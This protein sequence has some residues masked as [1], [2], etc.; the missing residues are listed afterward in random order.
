MPASNWRQAVRQ[1]FKNGHLAAHLGALLDGSWTAR[2][3]CS[4]PQ[5]LAG[6]A[7]FVC[8]ALFGGVVARCR[9]RNA[10]PPAVD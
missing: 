2:S 5:A 3:D 9:R 10:L 7:R 4:I 1:G 8:A 6:S